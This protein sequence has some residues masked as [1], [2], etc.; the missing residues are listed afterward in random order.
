MVIPEIMMVS[1]YDKKRDEVLRELDKFQS[2]DFSFS[3]G[4]ILGSM[5]THPHPIAKEAYLRFL[6]TNLGDPELFPGTKEI[7]SRLISFLSELLHAPEE[8]AGQIVSGGTEGNLTA[9]WLAK[10]LTGKKEI[11]LAENAHFSFRK[12]A[13]MMDMK[14]VNVPLTKDYNIDVTKVKSMVNR[15]TAA[16]L[17]IA[18]ST[19]LGTIDPI[20]ELSDICLDENLFLHVDA[21]FGGYVIPFLK[22]LNY[23]VP[24]FDFKLEGVST[25]SVDSHKMG[26]SAIPL[27][28]VIMRDRKWLDE[29]SVESFCISSKKQA[30]I[31]GTRSG[32]PVAAAYAVARYL[33][34]DGY[35]KLVEKCMDI[36]KYT[37]ERLEEIG[38]N[39][40][41]K[42]TMNVL[43]LKLKKLSK[44]VDK[45]AEY[46]W[47]V[48]V[49]SRLSCIR[50][51]IMPQ[52]TKEV[53]DRFIPV[54][55]KTCIEVGEL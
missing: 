1:N 38:L 6:E 46:G 11:I 13:S 43:G 29:I 32:G 54:L 47:R 31:L 53:M 9:M 21:A 52:I 20:P 27:G 7:E 10:R 50:I 22:E 16:V 44:V 48:N 12:I 45:L 14:L 49:M 36:T 3:S 28:V 34:R 15:D 18:G 41:T 8:A 40:V 4:R 37:E 33:G 2:E 35:R 23:E 39:L 24:D 30:G 55:K 25:V 5:C 42:P 19:E 26:Y 51:V 17:G